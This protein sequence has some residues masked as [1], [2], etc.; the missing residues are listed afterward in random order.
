MLDFFLLFIS[1]VVI[2][3]REKFEIIFS[4]SKA[5]Y[6]KTL[7]ITYILVWNRE[8]TAY[9][10]ACLRARWCICRMESKIKYFKYSN[11]NHVL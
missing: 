5:V 10:V 8:E 7:T 3:R 9:M 1:Q 4:D 2:F 11:N 6:K